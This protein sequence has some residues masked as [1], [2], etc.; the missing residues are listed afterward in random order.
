MQYINSKAH[1]VEV[2]IVPGGGGQQGKPA[3]TDNSYPSGTLSPKSKRHILR[4]WCRGRALGTG[5]IRKLNPN[6]HSYL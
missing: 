2:G 5:V 1:T 6:P 4:S 3:S